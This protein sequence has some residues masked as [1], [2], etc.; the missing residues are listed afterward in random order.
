MSDA[1]LEAEDSDE[2]QW[3]ELIECWQ[4]DLHNVI[5]VLAPICDS[6][7]AVFDPIEE[8]DMLEQN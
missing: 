5:D 1:E 2:H 3:I 8:H 7:R 4:R 6:D